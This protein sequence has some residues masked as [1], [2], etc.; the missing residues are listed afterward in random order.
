VPFGLLVNELTTNAIK[1]AFPEG[2][3]NVVISVALVEN[4][5]ELSVA[6]DGVGMSNQS[7]EKRP[8]NRGADYVTIFVRQL[9]GIIV[10][11]SMV[12]RGTTIKISLPLLRAQ[13]DVDAHPVA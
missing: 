1:H 8:E 3:G 2:N 6:D 4:Q 10:P 5:M 12:S 7:A 9:G 13:P 11:P